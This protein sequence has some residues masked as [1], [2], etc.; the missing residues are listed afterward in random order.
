MEKAFALAASQRADAVLSFSDTLTYIF[1]GRVADIAAA[2]QQLGHHPGLLR[3]A[4]LR[5]GLRC[6]GCGQ[7]SGD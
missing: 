7:N 5:I 6:G 4:A 2:E 1:A 3:A